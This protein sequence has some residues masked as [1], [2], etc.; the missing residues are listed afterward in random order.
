MS[1][2]EDLPDELL[3]QIL[4]FLIGEKFEK[5][6]HALQAIDNAKF[7]NKELSGCYTTW[8]RWERARSDID[9]F[10][11]ANLIIPLCG[12]NRHMRE[13]IRKSESFIMFWRRYFD[14]SLDMMKFLANAPKRINVPSVDDY[15]L[16]GISCMELSVGKDFSNMQ[17]YSKVKKRVEYFYST[18]VALIEIFCELFHDTFGSNV[19]V[20]IQSL[21]IGNSNLEKLNEVLKVIEERFPNISKLAVLESHTN[22][23]NQN[24][25]QFEISDELKLDH[26][27]IFTCSILDIQ[28]ALPQRFK[29]Q[30]KEVMLYES[31]S[32]MH[33]FENLESVGVYRFGG[34]STYSK[35]WTRKFDSSI[36]LV[37]DKVSILSAIS[38]KD[39]A[40]MYAFSKHYFSNLKE[41]YLTYYQANILLDSNFILPHLEIFCSD[42]L[43][44]FDGVELPKLWRLG[45]YQRRSTVVITERQKKL[46][47]LRDVSCHIDN[48]DFLNTPNLEKLAVSSYSPI[49]LTG[50][51]KLK[52]IHSTSCP[53][54]VIDNCAS[55]EY[56][57]TE[58]GATS[59]K[60]MNQKR[61]DHISHGL[62]SDVASPSLDLDCES[63][64]TIYVNVGT[65]V[66]QFNVKHVS[67]LVIYEDV[68][69]AKS[70]VGK[71][72]NTTV[73]ELEF[74]L[75]VGNE[76]EMIQPITSLIQEFKQV[77]R[78]VIVR[79]NY[80]DLFYY[81]TAIFENTETNKIADFLNTS[82][83]NEN[84]IY[85]SEL[86][87]S[88]K[89]EIHLE[90]KLIML[91]KCEKLEN[92]QAKGGII[93]IDL[94]PLKNLR[95]L[96]LTKVS[97]F[98]H[99]FLTENMNSISEI[100]SNLNNLPDDNIECLN[101]AMLPHIQ[102]IRISQCQS[103]KY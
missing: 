1:Q 95:K 27:E 26:L 3:M 62:Y 42:G 103:T 8:N 77:G 66:N 71:V 6:H 45:C 52:A 48:S 83:V 11:L 75:W 2:L 98:S 81:T 7:E 86:T 54:F 36:E 19:A 29:N 35:N 65:Q 82:L 47:S 31:L 100:I 74:N 46:L 59:L 55:L 76:T 4:K 41:L 40:L 25:P 12:V 30:L 92:L 88:Q 23:K 22:T 50:L 94:N 93:S 51:T 63:C 16:M 33:S 73:D 97:L 102:K 39:Q 69:I 43:T 56:V 96:Y 58:R 91:S 34:L 79:S 24:V 80:Q 85:T 10:D 84:T 99:S 101:L 32:D 9:Y 90:K 68:L 70:F 5:H 28:T 13:L 61:I 72:G 38:V 53:S 21:T 37:H 60:I 57:N 14:R 44:T 17:A 64:G 49:T 78:V 87:R 15:S 67:R 20:E 18:E 89:V